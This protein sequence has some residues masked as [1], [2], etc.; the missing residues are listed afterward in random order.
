MPNPAWRRSDPHIG[1]RA[2]NRSGVIVVLVPERQRQRH[3]SF[4]DYVRC[5]P[6]VSVIGGDVSHSCRTKTCSL[7]SRSIKKICGYP[8]FTCKRASVRRFEMICR[9]CRYSNLIVA[10]LERRMCALKPTL[11]PRGSRNPQGL[12]SDSSPCSK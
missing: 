3:A 7:P 11:F 4:F 10:S 6:C 12:S 2:A 9:P 1:T 8:P 5:P